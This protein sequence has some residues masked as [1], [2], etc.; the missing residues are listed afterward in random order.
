[1]YTR[2]DTDAT[3]THITTPYTRGFGHL[4][5]ICFADE[6][7]DGWTIGVCFGGWI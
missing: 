5:P 1:M 4:E 3:I 2:T 7:M 6:W